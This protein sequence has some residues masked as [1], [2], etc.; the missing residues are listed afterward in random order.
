MAHKYDRPDAE[1]VALA[2]Y[3]AANRRREAAHSRGCTSS[4]HSAACDEAREEA[5]KAA[6][7]LAET[8]TPESD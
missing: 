1:T 7:A 2:R 8:A 4:A 3:E 5:L 6:K